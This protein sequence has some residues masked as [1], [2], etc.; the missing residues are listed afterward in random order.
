MW[1]FLGFLGGIFLN[2]PPVCEETLNISLKP[3][4]HFIIALHWRHT[5]GYKDAQS[6][7]PCRSLPTKSTWVDQPTAQKLLALFILSPLLLQELKN[8]KIT[9]RSCALTG[10]ASKHHS[11]WDY[12]KRKAAR[13][14]SIAQKQGGQTELERLEGMHL[15][16]RQSERHREKMTITARPKDKLQNFWF[17]LN[18]NGSRIHRLN[19]ERLIC[20]CTVSS[21]ITGW[22]ERLIIRWLQLSPPRLP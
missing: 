1:A 15:C 11:H 10:K 19:L 18:C 14:Q 13:N 4:L 5:C 2:Y 3:M 22:C 9:E 6:L 16:K 7:F 17:W 8:I 12:K 20:N 21:A